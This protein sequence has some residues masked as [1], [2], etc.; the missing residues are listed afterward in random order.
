[1]GIVKLLLRKKKYDQSIELTK[2]T[3]YMDDEDKK[4]MISKIESA[5]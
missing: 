3:K 1:V 5:K 2:S 4:R